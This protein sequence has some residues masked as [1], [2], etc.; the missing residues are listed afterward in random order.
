LDILA[1][2]EAIA[3]HVGRTDADEDLVFDAIRA[4]LIEIGEAAKDLPP[5]MTKLEPAVPWSLISRMR[6]H[7]AHR[8]FDTTHA[9]VFGTAR[10]DVV[11]LH[12]AVRRILATIDRD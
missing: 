9:I 4:R 7:L 3:A 12:S 8:Y 5:E 6:D 11:V 10:D 1:A 2:C